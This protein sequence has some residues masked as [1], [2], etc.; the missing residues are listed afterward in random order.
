MYLY[1]INL[2]KVSVI[3]AIMLTLSSS[4][5]TQDQVLYGEG[6]LSNL[7]QYRADLIGENDGDTAQLDSLRRQIAEKAKSYKLANEVIR[8]VV[9]EGIY[10]WESYWDFIKTIEKSEKYSEIAG[11]FTK[12]DYDLIRHNYELIITA[13]SIFLKNRSPFEINKEPVL[14]LLKNLQIERNDV[15]ADIGTGTGNRGLLMA[16]L[17]LELKIYVTKISED[18][19]TYL[20]IRNKSWQQKD[21]LD[22]ITIVEGGESQLNLPEKC[23][24]IFMNKTFH[25][26]EQYE[27]ILSDVKANLKE[28]GML[29]ITEPLPSKSKRERTSDCRQLLRPREIKKRLKKGGFQIVVMEKPFSCS[30]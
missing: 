22:K 3:I 29:I 23:D 11:F 28:G 13:R 5:Y 1:I 8:R 14:E 4:A 2:M 24:K 30:L 16:M 19:L 18:W 21:Y 10:E 27:A 15:C 12:D 9:T 7:E 25:H 17:D 26:I 6:F 20:E